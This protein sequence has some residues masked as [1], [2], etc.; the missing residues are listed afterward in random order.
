LRNGRTV[1]D[2]TERP[3]SGGIAVEDHV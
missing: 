3:D 2:E 1:A